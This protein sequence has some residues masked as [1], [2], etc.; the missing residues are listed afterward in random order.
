MNCIYVCH[1]GRQVNNN[2]KARIQWID[3]E[4]RINDMV[5]QLRQVL[6]R[7]C[8]NNQLTVPRIFIPTTLMTCIAKDLLN[9]S[10]REPHGIRGCAI[11]VDLQS[12][13]RIF[14]LGRLEP[15]SDLITNFELYLVLREE[16]SLRPVIR[17][18]A[19]RVARLLGNECARETIYTS[20][21]YTIEK[22]KL[23]RSYS[24]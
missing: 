12:D 22:K 9:L 3:G 21:F 2:T 18:W 5:S 8:E 6:H 11:N 14:R 15:D 7:N 10:C 19:A 1:V 24:I 20:D 23:K 13:D 17:N 4:A 16:T